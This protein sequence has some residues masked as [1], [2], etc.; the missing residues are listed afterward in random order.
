MND[1]Q[2]TISNLIASQFPEVYR[3]EGSTLVAF[4]EA[5][6]EWLEQNFQLLT[7]ESNEG[8]SVGS[9]I[10]QGAVTGAIVSF[11]DND[12]L[13]KV[14]GLD[15]FKCFNVCSDLEPVTTTTNGIVYSTPLLKGGS[16]RRLG[17]LFQ[18]RNLQNYRDIDKTIDLFIGQFKEKYLSNIDFD[19]LSNKKLLIKNSL[20][21]Y[22]SKGTERSVDLFFRLVYGVN[23]EVKRPSDFLFQ[24]SG[25]EWTK[26]TYLEISP[27]TVQRAISLVGKEVTGVTSGAKAFVEKYIKLK[28]K[29]GFSH[30]LFVSNVKGTFIIRELLKGD[31]VYPDSPLIYG[32]LNSI[33][34]TVQAAEFKIGDIV[35]LNSVTG[36]NGLGRVVE[37]RF[38]SGQIEFALEDGGY[39]YS[40]NL[41]NSSNTASQTLVAD[42]L[43]TLSNVDIG[44]V[45]SF[46]TITSPGTGYS[47]TDTVSFDSNFGRNAV[48]RVVTNG[49]GQIVDLSFLDRGSGFVFEIPND[50][51]FNINTSSGTDAEFICNTKY[52]TEYLRLLEPVT[53]PGNIE[54]PEGIVVSIPSS[55]TIGIN[56]LQGTIVEG[57]SLFQVDPTLGVV[58]SGTV[59]RTNITLN[60][61]L[62]ALTNID[63]VFRK[64]YPIRNNRGS[65][66]TLSSIDSL[67]FGVKLNTPER[68]LANQDFL[69]T[70]PA[71]GL[72][73]STGSVSTGQDAS[74]SITSLLYPETVTVN[75]DLLNNPDVLNAPLNG[76]FNF[77]KLPTADVDSFLLDALTFQQVVIGKVRAIGSFNPGDGYSTTPEVLVYQPYVAALNKNDLTFGISNLTGSFVV[78]ELIE[79]NFTIPSR[80]LFV[81]N[82][83]DFDIG[84]P[85]NIT[86]GTGQVLSSGSILNIANSSSLQVKDITSTVDFNGQSIRSQLDDN[87]VFTILG[88]ITTQSDVTARGLVKSFDSRTLT[89]ER[90]SFDD[91]YSIGVEFTGTTSGVTANVVSI[92]EL[93]DD[94]VLGLNASVG[95]Q[96][97]SSNGTVVSMQVIDSGFGF[98]D[99]QE[100]TFLSTQ[101]NEGR[102]KVVSG[103]IGTGSG[104][105]RSVKGFASDRSKLFD[106]DYYQEYSYDILSKIP[107]SKYGQM[108]KEVMHTAGTKF[109]GSVVIDSNVD[110]GSSKTIQV[111]LG[112]FEIQ[113]SNTSPF[114]INSVNITGAPAP[115]NATE[116]TDPEL[117]SKLAPV[118]DFADINIQIRD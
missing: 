97:I 93:D 117:R 99:G 98:I 35:D 13:V 110:L 33:D 25:A 51:T 102:F 6:F 75:T 14:D 103:G 42:Q 105:Y 18:S 72:K 22:R 116:V 113:P 39:G 78:N 45:A 55:I 73:G 54:N 67:S 40:I 68:F 81:S 101:G 112:M 34:I 71:S 94:K 47:N 76:F 64:A 11:I 70:A 32:S 38:A 20:S 21:L 19:A 56:N 1:I 28:T 7:L 118:V 87:V 26:P 92:E 5:Y 100:G 84:E 108:F 77:P 50:I 114:T 16:S 27:D 2:V 17:T 79:Q 109:F 4:V 74:F 41:D 58:A 59:V 9:V 43:L 31:K 104:S 12:I 10:T 24:A 111:D 63:G 57:D 89:I 82:T 66:A 90:L 106:G 15:T 3:D 49:S 8:F 52:P 65:S 80:T 62:V 61:G 88:D 85:I 60:E 30:I 86:D 95:A 115:W 69:L 23:A 83:A 46:A 29:T 107:I 91:I 36:I 44:N 37:V 53:Q 96:T 48:A